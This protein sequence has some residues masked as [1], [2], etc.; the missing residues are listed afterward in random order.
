MKALLFVLFVI[1]G[2]DCQKSG[3]EAPSPLLSPAQQPSDLDWL[4]DP[5]H[6]TIAK[7]SFIHEVTPLHIAAPDSVQ[8]G[9]NVNIT[10]PA[11]LIDYELIARS[12]VWDA[13][14]ETPVGAYKIRVKPY[15]LKGPAAGIPGEQ[16]EF[17]VVVVEE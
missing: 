17:Y 13:D 15:L 16:R 7:S 5:Q 4:T 1:A 14:P 9:F 2:L 10:G 8:V 3:N 6:V 11:P 12:I